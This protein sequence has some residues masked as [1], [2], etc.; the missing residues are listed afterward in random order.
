MS[1][2]KDFTFQDVTI[3]PFNVNKSYSFTGKT[4]LETDNGIGIYYGINSPNI[5]NVN[6]KDTGIVNKLNSTLLYHSIKQLYYS[7]YYESPSGSK[8]TLPELI[9]GIT[10][11]DN[12][13]IGQTQSPLFDN[14]LQNT[15][16]QDRYFPTHS[17]AEISI[18]SIPSKLYGDYIVPNTF[19]FIYPNNSSTNII[20]LKDDGEGNIIESNKTFN[21]T[22][23]YKNNNTNNNNGY[24]ILTD[25]EGN[26]S[27][28][29]TDITNILIN[30]N[31]P[32]PTILNGKT[33]NINFY[34]ENLFYYL[35]TFPE[36]N[37]FLEITDSNNPLI[38]FK[39]KITGYT[40]GS[41]PI[42]LIIEHIESKGDLAELLHKNTYNITHTLPPTLDYTI[43]HIF[44]SH[45]IVTFTSG[46]FATSS[47]EITDIGGIRDESILYPNLL[48]LDIF[49]SSSLTLYEN[50]YKCTVRENEFQYTLN[51]TSL[52]GSSNEF[53]Y[54][55]ITGSDFKPYVS[56]V[57]L[58]NKEGD[59][60]LTGKLSQ[61]IPLSKTTDTTFQ[62]NFDFSFPFSNKNPTE[63]D[64]CN[65]NLSS[66]CSLILTQD[67][68][69][70]TKIDL[71]PE[72]KAKIVP[73]E[74]YVTG[75]NENNDFWP[76]IPNPPWKF[77]DI[78][79]I[80]R[81]GV[82]IQEYDHCFPQ[83]IFGS[84]SFDETC[85]DLGCDLELEY[86]TADCDLGCDLELEYITAS[87]DIDCNIENLD[88]EYIFVDF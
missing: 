48:K 52:S 23:R 19:E 54:N 31:T 36:K 3:A 65:I 39:F 69:G 25:G 17:N 8:V 81:F 37:I 61:P 66:S 41:N 21:I 59:L 45:G 67:C 53:Y 13:Y 10:L 63:L 64:S 22:R 80:I 40:P 44:Y 14:Y 85:C 12:T 87:C 74:I 7:N 35:N 6:E 55:F 76:R 15:L 57:G 78:G 16:L 43:G 83:V 50:Q 71:N 49:Y 88:F 34:R 68:D 1:V 42:N 72:C 9:P 60:L 11:E 46:N 73:G 4:A 56:T 27:I 24:F 70:V 20:I 29:F 38:Y 2:Y 58:Y 84:A 79:E 47:R 82:L 26:N 51:P 30:T 86:I 75:S 18:L 77:E 32:V 5:Y 28:T 62:I 33:N